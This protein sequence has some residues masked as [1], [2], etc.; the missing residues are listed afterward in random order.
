MPV[1]FK[2][3]FVKSI[4][5]IQKTNRNKNQLADFHL[6]FIN[7][8]DPS[9]SYTLLSGQYKRSTGYTLHGFDID[10]SDNFLSEGWY[11]FDRGAG[12]DIVTETPLKYQCGTI[13]PIW[14]QGTSKG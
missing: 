9:F 12:N 1:L 11:R 5:Y 8:A 6:F 13:F 4:L 3:V 14:L 7:I 10:I 2:H